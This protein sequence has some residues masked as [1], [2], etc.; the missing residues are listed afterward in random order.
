MESDQARLYYEFTLQCEAGLNIQEL[1]GWFGSMNSDCRVYCAPVEHFGAAWGKVANGELR[2]TSNASGTFNVLLTGLR[3]DPYA[4]DEWAHYGV[5]Y[6]DPN[7]PPEES[8]LLVNA[9]LESEPPG[10]GVSTE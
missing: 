5:E 2:V 6:P 8:A 4:V 9:D 3:S 10:G 7:A 1:P